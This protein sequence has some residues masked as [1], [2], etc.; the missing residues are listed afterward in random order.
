V[1]RNVA[2]ARLDRLVA[3]GML[4]TSYARRTGRTGPGGGR[5]TR[6]YHVL[7]ELEAIAY[8]ERRYERLIGR[9]LD[10]LPHRDRKRRLRRVGEDFGRE[11]AAAAGLGRA[12]SRRVG[13]EQ[14]CR[15]AGAAGFQT[16]LIE[17]GAGHA[18]LA[19]PTCPLRP[20]VAAR[21]DAAEIDRAM[22]AALVRA[23]IVADRAP[24]VS[25]ETEGCAD[26]RRPCRIE[27]H[28]G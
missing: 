19:S 26:A 11:L 22:W 25:C 7:P 18:V 9:L 15:A 27:I 20:L 28:F 10:E 21:S 4:T 12:R 8:P 1:H 3:A 16:T 2:A 17:E 6:L 5:P 24:R 23:S 14:L 13:L